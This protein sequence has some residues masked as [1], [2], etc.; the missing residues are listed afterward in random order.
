MNMGL[1]DDDDDARLSP[2]S[3]REFLEP[4]PPSG[5]LLPRLGRRESEPHTTTITHLVDALRTNFPG[6]RVLA[7][8]NHYFQ[9]GDQRVNLLPDVSFFKNFTIPESLSS[10]NAEDHGGRV[11]DLVVNVLSKSTWRED[12]GLNFDKCRTIGT[13]IYV[14]FAPYHVASREYRPPFLRAYV[15]AEDGTVSLAEVREICCKEGSDEIRETGILALPPELPF[16]LGLQQM[17]I[18]TAGTPTYTL[19]PVHPTQPRLLPRAVERERR[20]KEALQRELDAYR[21]RFG[22]LSDA[23]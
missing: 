13:P 1:I 23:S 11:P 18:Q 14:V 17:E 10:Y 4:G 21:K 8:L 7:D 20:Q 9:V 5:A 3:G 15:F 6:A 19:V 2:E 12:V 22:P 16:R